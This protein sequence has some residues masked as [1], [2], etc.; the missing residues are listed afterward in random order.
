M[1]DFAA[2]DVVPIPAVA[3]ATAE[4][5]DATATGAAIPPNEGA[6]MLVIGAY[7][8]Y[9][10]I[11]RLTRAGATYTRTFVMRWKDVD[12]VG[13][14]YRTWAVLGTP[15]PAGASF[16]A[17][18]DLAGTGTRSGATPITGAVVQEVY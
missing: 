14:V 9:D 4:P 8:P 7:S 11:Q 17:L 10:Q 2:Q 16:N 13:T 5:F 1:A 12:A 3:L 15:D 18:T 6:E